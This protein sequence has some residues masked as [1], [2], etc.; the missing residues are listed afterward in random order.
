MSAAILAKWSNM[1]ILDNYPAVVADQH[2]ISTK[3]LCTHSSHL[4]EQVTRDEKV[5]VYSL[6]LS[7]LWFDQ[8]VLAFERHHADALAIDRRVFSMYPTLQPQLL[9]QGQGS[10][11][12][13]KTSLSAQQSFER[14]NDF[15]GSCFWSLT[16]ELGA[17]KRARVKRS[18]ANGCPVK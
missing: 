16:V 17:Q 6:E 10:Y 3:W 11:C 7:F 5:C 8:V 4:I 9:S 1:I 12:Y 18:R 15:V 2:E 14:C 13:N